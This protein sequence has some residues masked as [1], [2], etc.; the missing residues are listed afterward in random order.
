MI[1]YL[2]VR[3]KHC[4]GSTHTYTAY[5]IKVLSVT[6]Q[7]TKILVYIPDISLSRQAVV[8]LAECC[9]QKHLS[10]IHIFDVIEDFL[11]E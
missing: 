11:A 9:T 10:P 1:Y 2:P 5:G 7:H 6:Q 4:I 3:E 8:S